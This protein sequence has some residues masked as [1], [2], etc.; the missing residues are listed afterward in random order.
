VVESPTRVHDT[1]RFRELALGA[2]HSCGIDASS[3]LGMYCWG[4]N[5]RGQLGAGNTEPS[6]SPLKI[7]F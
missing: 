2:A 3:Q 5:D 1:L 4:Q 6:L 7:D